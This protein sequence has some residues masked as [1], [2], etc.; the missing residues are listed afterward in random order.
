[1]GEILGVDKI[2]K[3]KLIF[4]YLSVR[5]PLCMFFMFAKFH[6]RR[7]PLTGDMGENPFLDLE[8]FEVRLAYGDI[9]SRRLSSSILDRFPPYW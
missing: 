5:I 8:Y 2:G 6:E 7:L 1:M 4:F 9:V 3:M